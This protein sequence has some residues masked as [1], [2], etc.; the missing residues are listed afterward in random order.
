MD[1]PLKVAIPITARRHALYSERVPVAEQKLRDHLLTAQDM[2][3]CIEPFA[4]SISSRLA[5]AS[6]IYQ[7]AEQGVVYSLGAPAPHSL[8][9][10]LTLNGSALGELSLT[11]ENP[12]TLQEAEWL[13]GQIGGFVQGLYRVLLCRAEKT[14]SPG[15]F[16]A[17]IAARSSAV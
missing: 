1:A 3:K 9:Y 8:T 7:H 4:Q 14:S 16:P 6:F 12:F 10:G 13:E 11:S 15:S 5:Q 17:R 2:A